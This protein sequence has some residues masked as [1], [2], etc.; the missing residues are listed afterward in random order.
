MGLENGKS[1]YI[2]HCRYSKKK[3]KVEIPYDPQISLLD[4]YSKVSITR[5][6]RDIC[7]HTFVVALF[8]IPRDGHYLNVKWWMNKENVIYAY[9]EI[10][11]SIIKKKSCHM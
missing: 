9:K 7:P 8:T 1:H 4:V 10:L 3:L 2:K 11:V 6:W 5:F